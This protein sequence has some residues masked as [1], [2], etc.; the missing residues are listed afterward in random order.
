MSD[1]G[2]IPPSSTLTRDDAVSY[3]DFG[4]VPD[5]IGRSYPQGQ[6]P[7][8]F[9]FRLRSMPVSICST[10]SGRTVRRASR[11]LRTGCNPP[12]VVRGTPLR[13]SAAIWAWMSSSWGQT[14]WTNLLI[15]LLAMTL[16]APSWHGAT[17]PPGPVAKVSIAGE[18]WRPLRQPS[19]SRSERCEARFPRP[20]ELS[21]G[22]G[23]TF[24]PRV[25]E[26]MLRPSPI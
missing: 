17:F 12:P 21:Y 24:F 4:G 6:P 7:V 13:R 10:L 22:H 3:S 15:Q 20:I 16:P 9:P 23:V 26:E 19:A 25:R 2:S 11:R 14:S 1:G 5:G 8:L 18:R